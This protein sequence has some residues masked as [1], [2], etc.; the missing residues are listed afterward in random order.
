MEYVEVL[1]DVE[2]LKYQLA[3]L[4]DTLQQAETKNHDID[5]TMNKLKDMVHDF[6]QFLTKILMGF[7]TSIFYKLQKEYFVNRKKTENERLQ[8]ENKRLRCQEELNNKL[9][10]Q[11]RKQIDPEKQELLDT[12]EELNQKLKAI[13]TNPNIREAKETKT[14][15][16]RSF[17]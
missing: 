14:K 15:E 2:V 10:K 17:R 7:S 13:E 9:I 1:K 6:H 11:L 8:S 12:I 5:H 4:F 3:G 16:K